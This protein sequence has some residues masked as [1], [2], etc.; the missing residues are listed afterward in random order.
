MQSVV[1]DFKKSPTFMRK[2][3]KEFDVED[4]GT[5]CFYIV[6][7]D[8]ICDDNISDCL[9]TDN[10]IKYSEEHCLPV[11]VTLKYEE[12]NDNAY[13]TVDGDVSII[14]PYTDTYHSAITSF[15]M[16]GIFV[17]NDAG[18]VMG[19]SINQYSVNVNTKFTIADGLKLWS[20]LEVVNNGE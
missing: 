6:L 16:K 7:V 14:F 1:M 13:L 10:Q 2:W 8:D 11:E 17:T 15:N 4:I 18:Y 19:Y 5:N 9:N 3:N 20:L 12:Q